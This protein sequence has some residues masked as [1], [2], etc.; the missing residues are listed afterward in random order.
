M[1]L[2]FDPRVVLISNYATLPATFSR[3]FKILQE[4]SKRGGRGKMSTDVGYCP[5]S[6]FAFMWPTVRPKRVIFVSSK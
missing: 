4:D 2:P 1:A 5:V 3:F 6:L